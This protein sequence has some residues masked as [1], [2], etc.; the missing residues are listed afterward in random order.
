MIIQSATWGDW[1]VDRHENRRIDIYKNGQRFQNSAAAL[2]DIAGELGLEINPEWRTARLGKYVIDKITQQNNETM[3]NASST[4]D[5]RFIKPVIDLC[6]GKKLK[7]NLPR[8]VTII[9]RWWFPKD[10]LPMKFLDEYIKE[11]SN[12]IGALYMRSRL[13]TIVLNETTYYALY[14]GKSV[15]GR[16][17]F[18]QHIDGDVSTSTLRKTIAAILNKLKGTYTEMDIT[19]VL[20][21]C[22]FEWIELTHDKELMNIIETAAVS[23]G[24]Y[25]LNIEGNF[26]V[27]DKWLNVILDARRNI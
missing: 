20:K 13:K 18:R 19:K 24:Y 27:S 23:Y 7:T 16:N 3:Q 25:P 6:N 4:F 17:R 15:N 1:K 12:D 5:E 26:A 9:Y 21:G 10:S 11:N 2:R 22:Y 14:V 8:P